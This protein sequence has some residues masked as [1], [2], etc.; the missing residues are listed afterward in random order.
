MKKRQETKDKRQILAVSPSINLPES[1]SASLLIDPKDLSKNLIKIRAS[2]EVKMVFWG[3]SELSGYILDQ[4]VKFSERQVEGKRYIVQAVIT[5]VDKPVGRKQ[6]MTPTPVAVVADK[7]QIPVLKPAK[8]NSDFSQ[9]NL[10]LFEADLYVVAAYGKIIPQAVL[11]IPQFGAL[12]VHSSLLPKYRGASPIQ[13][14]I[15]NGDEKT[16]VAIML[17]D[18]QMDHGP[19]L[20]TQEIRLSDSE[21]TQS[22]SQK[23]AQLGADLLI[24]TIPDFIAG[25]INL[26][27][28]NHARA[29]FCTLVKKEDGYFEIDNPPPPQKLDRMIRAYYSWPNVWTR[30]KGKIVKFYPEG[31]MQMEGKNIVSKEEFSRGYPDFPKLSF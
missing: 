13:A 20:K 12:N 26:R 31:K 22:L 7:Y 24:K 19:I 16:G 17:V 9:A 4:L 15:L 25:R 5:R 1:D 10:N 2:E 11:D 29:S 3:S 28:Q 6:V 30:W 27:V 14:A 23:M 21:T 18:A 8:L